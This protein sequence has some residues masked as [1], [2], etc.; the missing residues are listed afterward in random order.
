MNPSTALST[1][2]RFSTPKWAG[3]VPYSILLGARVF[4]EPPTSTILPKPI[5]R[6]I[7]YIQTRFQASPGESKSQ[8]PT[9]RDEINEEE[10]GAMRRRLE[11]LE[12]ESRLAHPRRHIKAIQAQESGELSTPHSGS[13]DLEA[14]K[15]RLSKKIQKADF[16]S[17]YAGSIAYSRLSDAAGRETRET[18]MA[19]P[20]AGAESLED[21]VLRSLHEATPRLR[22]KATAPTSRTSLPTNLAPMRRM[23][24]NERIVSA[25]DRAG[26]YP[27]MKKNESE[28]NEEEKEARS[29]MF[30]ERFEPG[31]RAMPNTIQGLTALANEK[32][33]EAI[34]K[35]MFKNLPKGPI[36]EDH[37][38]GSPFIDTTE[39]LL[40]RM[41][42][43]QEIV[44]P[45][46]EKQQELQKEI[47]SFRGRIRTDWKRHVV[48]TIASW[49]GTPDVWIRRAE[50]YAKAEQ[51]A[52]PNP[53]TAHDG[54]AK[55]KSA[56]DQIKENSPTSK[57]LA[58]PMKEG[59]ATAKSERPLIPFRDSNWERNE[60]AY[61]EASIKTINNMTRSY[62][63]QAPS[64]AQRPFVTLRR[65]ILACYRDIMPTI[66]AEMIERANNP[67][68]GKSQLQLGEL[69][70]GNED[71][72]LLSFLSTREKGKVYD[73]SEA[74]AYG[75]KQFWKDLFSRP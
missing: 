63:L 57:N 17:E 22:G 19:R 2:S 69:K 8:A 14:L 64:I 66:P 5:S 73:E 6:N 12:E 32:I 59:T 28:F 55:T 27:L 33:E 16:E 42:Q 74:K 43:R 9:R 54:S 26:Q 25:R 51:I 34:S 38:A 71:K 31:A 44:P 1:L 45:W 29:R 24:K 67:N 46:I 37:H 40:N 68:Y 35:G 47:R 7:S 75:F 61:H 49:G 36:N 62:N 50:E 52:N 58:A 60:L 23:S 41:I 13:E 11:D 21:S 20:W 10:H 15:E 70:I 39:Y 30:K 18:A 3:S 72:N 53:A 4:D 48:R 56:A 65:E